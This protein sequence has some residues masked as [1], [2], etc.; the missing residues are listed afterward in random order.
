MQGRKDRAGEDVTFKIQS[1]G[2]QAKT[3]LS[4]VQAR[5][6]KAGQDVMFRVRAQDDASAALIKVQAE[7]D[8]VG[9][10]VDIKVKTETDLG[11][12]DKLSEK[13]KEL[14]EGPFSL[15]KSAIVGLGP[16]AVP[17]AGSIIA[18]F[19][20][21]APAIGS[22]VIGLEAFGQVAKLALTP[23][24]TAATAVLK[25]QAAYNTALASGTKQATAYAAE[26]KAIGTAYSGMSAQQIAVAKQ[27]EGLETAWKNVLKSVTPL[28]S[29]DLTPWLKDV[30]GLLG[31]LKPLIG[32]IANDFKAWGQELGQSLSGNQAKIKS[33][34]GVFAATSAGN[35][36]AFGTA[37]VS[38]A[39]GAGA[40][41]HDVAPELAGASSGVAGLAASF[42]KWAGSQKTA[43]DIKAFF[44]WAHAEAP[45]VRQFLDSLAG[46]VTSLIKAMAYSGGGDLRVLTTALQAIGALPA[47]AIVAIA[48][49]YLAI[50]VGLRAA[51]AAMVVWNV[52]STVAKGIQAA[53]SDE[54]KVTGAA[55]AIQKIALLA[56][57]AATAVVDAAETIYIA[58][59][60]AADAA[61][62]PLIV[63]IGGVV[64]AIAALSA[65]VFELVTHWSTV[66]HAILAA[67][68]DVFNWVKANWPLLLGI[69]TGPVGLA[70]VEFVKYWSQI[71]AGVSTAWN[72]IASFFTGW[73][74]QVSAN[75][76][77]NLDN[78]EHIFTAAWSVVS[79]GV[80]SAWN[81]ISSFFG[82]WWQVE[83]SG[84]KKDI[85]SFTGIFRAAWNT[86][87]SDAKAIWNAIKSFFGSWWSVE[88]SGWQKTISTFTGFFRAAWNT[89][90]SDAKSIW[91]AI[92]SWFSGWWNAELS[93]WR[94]TISTV[95]NIFRAAWNSI[96][97][98]VKSVW[99]NIKSWF[100]SFWSSLES[101]FSSV[102]ARIK[103]IWKGFQNDISAP[104]TWVINN[105][106]DKYI[107]R[108][109][110]DVAG[111]VGLPKL[112]GLAEGGMVPGGYS[113]A[114]NQL[115]WMRS[116]EGV[117][118]P[119][120]VSALGGPGFINWAN[121]TYGDIP[122]SG[123]SAPGHYA[124]G[125][126]IPGWFHD[127]TSFLGSPI[128]EVLSIG[129]IIENAVDDGIL[130][131]FK[132]IT[133]IMVDDLAKMPGPKGDGMV[134]IMQKLPVKLW[135]GFVN[136]VGG[137]LPFVGGATG[138]GA[139][140]GPGSAKGN[141]ITEFAERYLGTPYVFGGTQPGLGWDCSGFTEFVYD[142]F[143]WTPP[144][145]S[146]EQFGWVKRIT[147]PVPGAL[148]FFTGSPI[149]PPPGHVGIVTSPDTMIDA[150]GTGY[151]TIYN[152]IYG[153][154][155][156]V[157]GFG[158][159]PSGF[160]FDDGGWLQPGA[161]LVV[162]STGRPEPVLTGEQWGAVIGGGP[163]TER[164]DMIIAHLSALVGATSAAPGAMASG[165][166][167]V[168]NGSARNAAFRRRYG[169][170]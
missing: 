108:F 53:L 130:A 80:R 154:S 57:A 5:K 107:V 87:E 133:R 34:I 92:K 32:P 142:H 1:D 66:W 119:G 14:K 114:D 26:Q 10:D 84:W 129:K 58:L 138:P 20:P 125:G 55:L 90:E 23:A 15:L 19:A 67:A 70:V 111:A 93:A 4:D 41:I 77:K 89:V 65:G 47:S 103:S 169:T 44:E 102:V 72:A 128:R 69:L 144:R 28:I 16:A 96:Y 121:A 82:S 52:V 124:Q 146:E 112:K 35:I 46:S 78:A 164:L 149:D 147:T 43:D 163:A 158:I 134:G 150:Y 33:F 9:G 61:S 105:V 153:S 85:S 36:Y 8:R 49:A 161:S 136:W 117:L 152:S 157:M 54:V 37:L 116:G 74:S 106:Y 148:A 137:H 39:K 118:Q 18:A 62:L 100:G 25:A 7:K 81:A 156:T 167:A 162:N 21:L 86:V 2:G 42:D 120:A 123:P 97:S 170:R 51:S 40:L 22:S 48:D 101:G 168:L 94:G 141:A 110:N 145:T 135:D 155:G 29:S 73:W 3:A 159:P 139:L 13:V 104:V 71:K 63:V 64:L 31:Y 59:M 11:G 91:N 30:Q 76:T 140:S 126:L 27:A 151:G 99:G 60:L 98:N 131:P 79:S 75:W 166:G 165:L 95:E 115:M 17:V 50:S 109:W 83:I 38:F 24:F 88:I 127:V 45:V 56:M 122:V 132:A 160:K 113:R 143:G 12:L 6:D 68:R